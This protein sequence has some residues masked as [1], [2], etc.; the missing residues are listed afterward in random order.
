MPKVVTEAKAKEREAKAREADATRLELVA[1]QAA[2]R[3]QIEQQ[4]IM[5]GWSGGVTPAA[6]PPPAWGGGGGWGRGGGGGGGPGGGQGGLMGGMGGRGPHGMG[7]SA[8]GLSKEECVRRFKELL[9]DK[10]V[11]VWVLS[12]G[13]ASEPW[14]V[15]QAV[16]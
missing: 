4:R 16:Y 3:A 13:R 10:G 7:K 14:V 9:M 6:P 15:R 8:P 1:K 5:Q 11:S 12:T 2:M